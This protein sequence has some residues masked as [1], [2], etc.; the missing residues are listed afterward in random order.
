M[1][2]FFCAFFLTK[3]AEK[4]HAPFCAVRQASKIGWIVWDMWD[5]K[6]PVGVRRGEVRCIF[7]A[8]FWTKKKPT[9]LK[10]NIL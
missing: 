10:I 1:V 7:G 3:T 4:L 6:T 8:F 9:R 2:P 5:L